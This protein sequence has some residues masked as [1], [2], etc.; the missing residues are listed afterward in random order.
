MLHGFG[1]CFG[2]VTCTFQN[3]SFPGHY[4]GPCWDLDSGHLLLSQ[5]RWPER[6][7]GGAATEQTRAG[8]GCRGQTELGQGQR[9]DSWR[10]ELAGGTHPRPGS[11]GAPGLLGPVFSWVPTRGNRQQTPTTRGVRLGLFLAT[12]R[13]F[14][15]PEQASLWFA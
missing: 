10:G 3:Q 9:E 13:A 8:E 11:P 4:V 7:A 12:K 5:E 6:E 2:G 15:K 14:K 1:F